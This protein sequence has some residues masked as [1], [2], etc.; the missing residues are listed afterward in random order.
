MPYKD[1]D[2]RRAHSR[3]YYA[4]NKDAIT[5]KKLQWQKR[6]PERRKS[7]HR[8]YLYGLSHEEYTRIL[9]RQNGLCALCDSVGPLTVDHCHDTG[10]VRGL[11]CYSCNTGIGRFGDNPER[12]TK[13]IRY[14]RQED[15]YETIPEGLEG[16]W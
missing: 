12:L 10:R 1:L 16:V 11:L 5:A 14:L 8:K 9:G 2:A 15:E 13:A 7:Y 3:R 4:E 6:H